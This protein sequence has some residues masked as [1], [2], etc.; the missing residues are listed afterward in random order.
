MAT[1]LFDPD[2][3]APVTLMEHQEDVLPFI[4]NGKILYGGV[5]AGKSLTAMAYYAESEAPRDIYVITTAK[6]RDSLE[7]VG[8]AA[9]YGIGTD[10]DSTLAGV[11]TVDSWN[12]IGKYVDV[13]DAFF[14]F[15]EQRVVGHGAWVRSFLK[16]VK[17][18]RWILLSATPG[19][20]WLDYAPVFIANGWYRNLTDFKR[21][22]V[23]YAPFTKYPQVIGYVGEEK[24]QALRN[25]VL[26]EMPYVM[27]TQ[28][29]LNYMDVSYDK[30]LVK[31]VV[32]NRWNI[33][34]DKPVK[35]AAELWRLVR[36]IVN[37]D[38]SRFE[39]IKFLLKFHPKLIIFYNFDYEL[40][41]LRWLG[42]T[43]VC[44][45]WN[46]HHKD[47]I[48]DSDTWVYLV[49]YSAG[50]EGW[51][52]TETDS[53]VLYSLTYSYKSFVQSQGRIDR[54]NTEFVELYYYVLS[55][56][57]IVDLAVKKAIAGKRDFN[58]REALKNP[59][60][61][62]QL[63]PFDGRNAGDLQVL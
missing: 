12:N 41:I 33:Y 10:S 44:A 40:D 29:I 18:N 6:K 49:Q 50:G 11:L 8:E 63:M 25:E 2:D 4:G 13:K 24:L 54:L 31:A 32:R 62:F 15:D 39:T 48:P 7:W 55:S 51:N 37:S 21:Q 45:E 53:M 22:H 9:K 17:R 3:L 42:D 27:H 1:C 60:L 26:V 56:N 35:D 19:D 47:S 59:G 23:L 43:V 16:I 57:S 36:R 58:E 5:G 46:G 28:R 38:P 52:C 30:E 20:T 61:N 14:I 34:E